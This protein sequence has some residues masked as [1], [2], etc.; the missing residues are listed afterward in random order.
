MGF[1]GRQG[2][3]DGVHIGNWVAIPPSDDRCLI[4][5]CLSFCLNCTTFWFWSIWSVR[6][7]TIFDPAR[8]HCRAS[9][10]QQDLVFVYTACCRHGKYAHH[11][12]DRGRLSPLPCTSCFGMCGILPGKSQRGVRGIRVRVFSLYGAN[13]IPHSAGCGA[14]PRLQYLNPTGQVRFQRGEEMSVAKRPGSSCKKLFVIWISRAT[15]T[16]V[17]YHKAFSPAKSA[18]L[19]DHSF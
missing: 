4:K 10:I 11:G 16:S 1:A 19:G 15:T 6:P 8:Y 13:F 12:F 14:R 2:R 7:A 18:C 3:E 17:C 9:R 5:F